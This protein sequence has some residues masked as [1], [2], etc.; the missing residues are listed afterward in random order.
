MS[1]WALGTSEKI[2]A[3][4]RCPTG[5]KVPKHSQFVVAELE[6]MQQSGEESSQD[7]TQR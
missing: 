7:G 5:G 2:S 3:Q 1:M 6:Q 4:C